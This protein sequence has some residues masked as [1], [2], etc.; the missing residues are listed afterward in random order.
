MRNTPRFYFDIYRHYVNRD[1]VNKYKVLEINPTGKCSSD[2]WR[3]LFD[4]YKVVSDP[5]EAKD[6]EFNVLLLD[7]DDWS[8][9]IDT[10]SVLNFNNRENDVLEVI[11]SQKDDFF[12]FYQSV[13]NESMKWG[14]DETRFLKIMGDF[15]IFPYKL[16]TPDQTILEELVSNEGTYLVYN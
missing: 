3:Q 9:T 1:G 12:E 10:L 8:K 7:L 5:N 14:D 13:M 11:I 6:Y 2:M 4:T 15:G 16:K